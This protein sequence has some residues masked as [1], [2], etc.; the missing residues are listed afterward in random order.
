MWEKIGDC[1][2]SSNILPFLSHS[3]IFVKN[4]VF[5]PVSLARLLAVI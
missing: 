4:A 2:V 3:T 1:E 5:G